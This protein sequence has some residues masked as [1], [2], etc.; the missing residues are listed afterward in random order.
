MKTCTVKECQKVVLCRGWCRTHY[1]RWYETG[2]TDLGVRPPQRTNYDTTPIEDRF[3]SK[4][5]KT[6]DHWIWVGGKTKLGYGSVWN[7]DLKKQVMAH[8]LSWEIANSRVIPNELHID[9]LC[10]TPSCVNPNHL[11]PVTR[12]VNAQRG[13]AGQVRKQRALEQTHCINGHI[14]KNNV[15]NGGGC[16]TCAKI[17]T[18]RRRGKLYLLKGDSNE[19]KSTK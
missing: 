5:M 15:Y 4:V 1:T 17:N 12:K 18:Y 11:E 19:I 16:K 8:R 3:W 9:H 6:S 10:R 14:R 13:I 2:S 7:N